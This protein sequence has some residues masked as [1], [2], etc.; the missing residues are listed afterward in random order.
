MM[1]ISYGKSLFGWP[2]AVCTASAYKRPL[3][4]LS[5]FLPWRSLGRV[6]KTD[7]F[8][9]CFLYADVDCALCSGK[10]DVEEGL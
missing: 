10:R 4:P 5:S 1:E 2:Y 7:S 8:L 3:F 6:I 9:D